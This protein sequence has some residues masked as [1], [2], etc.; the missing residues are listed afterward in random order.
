MQCYIIGQG[1]IYAA[2]TCQSKRNHQFSDCTFWCATYRWP[3]TSMVKT[4]CSSVAC[5]MIASLKKPISKLYVHWPTDECPLWL[6]RVSEGW[7]SLSEWLSNEQQSLTLVLPTLTA[8]TDRPIF[9]TPKIRTQTFST[10]S[11]TVKVARQNGLFFI[12]GHTISFVQMPIYKKWR[13]VLW[14]EDR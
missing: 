9:K 14:A 2:G 11:Q 12:A 10:I 6:V 5:Q 7:V 4:L 3:P 13:H 8:D 1:A